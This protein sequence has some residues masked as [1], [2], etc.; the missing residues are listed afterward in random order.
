MKKLVSLLTAIVIM[1]ALIPSVLAD[2]SDYVGSYYSLNSDAPGYAAMDIEACSDTAIRLRFKREKNGTEPF[3]FIFQEGVVSGDNA[4]IP[5]TATVTANGSTFSGVML[6][7]FINGMVNVQ[8][9]S[10]QYV[11]MYTGLL[12]KVNRSY[13]TDS[14]VPAVNPAA[15]A[16]APTPA[17]ASAPA[18]T[19]ATSYDVSVT[20]NG[21]E[22]SF[23]ESARPLIRNN[24]TYVP[25][26]SV[27]SSMGINVYWDDYQ[28]NEQLREQLIT[29]TKNDTII[30]FSRTSNNTG[31]NVWTLHKWDNSYTSFDNYSTVD[32][33]MLQPIIINNR[34]YVPLRVISESL[35]ADVSWDDAARSVIINCDTNNTFWYD[36]ETIAKMEDYSLSEALGYIPA[37]FTVV[38]AESTPYFKPQ[39]KFYQFSAKFESYDVILRVYYRGFMDVLPATSSASSPTANTNTSSE[40]AVEASAEPQPEATAADTSAVTSSTVT[41][42]NGEHEVFTFDMNQLLNGSENNGQ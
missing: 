4:V 36:A 42:E 18:A 3:T 27:F 37:D 35:G 38:N 22:L 6:L 28:K 20:L 33:T 39:S 1:A 29:C 31:A 24:F 19:D 30:Q 9:T 25:L 14:A 41:D 15:P 13:F 17:P 12:P 7:E 10:D 32:I 5:Y 2:K 26:R 40:T 21:T 34:S 23:D 16:P 8:L 11:K